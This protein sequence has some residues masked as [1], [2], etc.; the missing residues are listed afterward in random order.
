VPC[1]DEVMDNKRVVELTPLQ[2][3]RPLVGHE[4]NLTPHSGDGT[5]EVP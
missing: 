5:E 1:P 4:S 3:P 2:S